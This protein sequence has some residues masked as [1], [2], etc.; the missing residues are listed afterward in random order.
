[1]ASWWSIFTGSCDTGQWKLVYNLLIF[2]E[3]AGSVKQLIISKTGWVIVDDLQRKSSE[4]VLN[5]ILHVYLACTQNN[6]H[7]L[8]YVCFSCQRPV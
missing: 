3:E 8:L 7:Y 6:S 2:E 1:M 5:T 4:E